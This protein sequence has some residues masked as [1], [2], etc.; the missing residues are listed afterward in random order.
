MI[1]SPT[2]INRTLSLLCLAF[3][4]IPFLSGCSQEKME[5]M[6]S[7]AKEKAAE[8]SEKSGDAFDH[9]KATA[10]NAAGM[11]K[12]KANETASAV[13][14]SASNLAGSAS[15]LAGGALDMVSMN[16]GAQITLDAPT[17]FLA[18]HVRLIELGSDQNVFQIKSN[19]KDG[20]TGSFPAF[21]IQGIVPQT[22]LDSLSGQ[23]IPCRLFAQKSPDGEVWENVAGQLVNVQF[24]RSQDSFTASFSAARLISS[25]GT[26]VVSTG[27]F[28]C[29]LLQ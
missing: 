5:K 6:V 11:I 1:F 17:K 9:A 12:E 25:S 13:K 4:M 21:F 27:K 3:C 18:A 26:Q 29:V 16:G 23:T 2:A 19:S 22:S 10:S 8:L 15:D 7:Q 20:Q 14:D 24:Q 28:D